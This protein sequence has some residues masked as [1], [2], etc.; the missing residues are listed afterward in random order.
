MT[1]IQEI[2]RAI[3]SDV[4]KMGERAAALSGEVHEPVYVWTREDISNAV[5]NGVDLVADELAGSERD[6]DLMNMVVNAAMTLLENPHY[7]L[8]EVIQ[9]CY[10]EDPEEVRS[11]WSGW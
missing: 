6:A 9:E 8:D 11:W 10:D 3:R 7:T 4:V 5:N 2:T 1:M